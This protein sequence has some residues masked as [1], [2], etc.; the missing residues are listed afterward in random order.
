MTARLA[1]V[2]GAGRGYGAV[3]ARHLAAAG[4]TVAALGRDEAAVNAI[5]EEVG[6][7][8]LIADVLDR[9]RVTSEVARLV[10][11]RGAPDVLVN[12]AGVGGA[13]ALAWEADD[14]E[15]WRTVEVNVRGTHN[16]T[17][18]TV[19]SMIAA[20]A[21]R[22]INVVSHAGT[23]RW[24]YGSAYVVSKAGVIK[25]G[26]NLAAETRK[27]GLTVFNYNPG[28]LEI[29]LTATLFESQ[30]AEGTL[31]AMVA[32][33]FRTQ[34]AEGRGADADASAA[35]LTRI[36]LGDADVLSGRY[37]TAYDDLDALVARSEDIAR[38]NAY[39]LG[40]LEP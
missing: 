33:W 24:P 31:D 17:S 30:P 4:V 40:L 3:V 27:L 9:E 28:I 1:L 16:V 37:L 18:A 39:T 14:D 34:I 22:V 20:G 8:A 15:W 23:A 21:G 5:A 11:D 2:T 26:E 32:D 12:N 35:L 38:S 25:Y 6:G 36:A 19:P 10:A 13:F 29:G 7:V